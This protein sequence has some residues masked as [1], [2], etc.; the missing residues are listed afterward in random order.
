MSRKKLIIDAAELLHLQQQYDAR[1][2]DL[3]SQDS[4]FAHH[5]PHAVHIDISLFNRSNPPIN[6]LLPTI[7]DFNSTI[8]W[9]DI[10]ADQLL[11]AYDDAAT[12]VAGRFV[13]VMLAYGHQNVM[14]LNG[15]YQTWLDQNRAISNSLPDI[16]PKPY[17]GQLQQKRIADTEHILQALKKNTVC[18]IDT[19][20]PAEFVGDDVRSARG[21]H[22]PGAVNINW[23]QLKMDNNPS[24]FKEESALEEL[25][26]NAEIPEDKEIVCYCQSHQRSTLL[27]IVLEH[28]G[29]KNVKGYP[30]AWSDWG[31]KEDTPIE[32]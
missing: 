10:T 17:V 25:L 2:V 23:T 19:R 6:G 20:S 11:I 29:Y 24:L 15:G 4:Y 18:I 32:K 3:R 5:I 31:N 26:R 28:L 21:G 8:S 30:G 9:L 7:E 14:M 13:W 1:I 27:C 16:K 12:P 22:I